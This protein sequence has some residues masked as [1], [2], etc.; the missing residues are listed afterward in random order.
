MPGGENPPT[1]K[2]HHKTEESKRRISEAIKQLWK[3]PGHRE[4]ISEIMSGS[5]SSFYGKEPWNKGSK[6]LVKAWNKGVHMN[7]DFCDKMKKSNS[8]N[9][10]VYKDGQTK[11]IKLSELDEYLNTGW[12]RGK[13]GKGHWV[14][15]NGKKRYVL[16]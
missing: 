7:A 4:H 3:K 9:A 12:S 6:G 11:R 14:E 13:C 1:S 5:G 2:G 16:N 10:F 15:I 8:G